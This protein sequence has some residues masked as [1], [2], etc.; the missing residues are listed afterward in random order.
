M[1]NS[2]YFTGKVIIITGA[3]SGIGLAS[4]RLFGSYGAKVV[5]AARR[6][7]LLQELGPSIAPS[8]NLLCVRCDVTRESDCRALIDAAIKRFSRIDILV[9]NAGVSMRAM[10]LDVELK[11]LKTLMDV[12]Y[13][14]TVYCTKAALPWLLESRGT[15]AGIISV[16][17]ISSLPARSGYSSSK[18]AVR[19]FLDAL[20]IE[21]LKDGLNV[22]VFAPGYTSSNVRNAA[23]IADGSPQ[24]NTPLNE[25]GLMSAEKVALKLAKAIKRRRNQVIL[26]SLGRL[27]AFLRGLCPSLLDRITYNYIAREGEVPK[28]DKNE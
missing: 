27:T 25:A 9:N 12:N 5:A 1:N 4:A 21:H 2:A 16:A 22:L 26:T 14:G 3:S 15:L 19:G 24:G 8:E 18:F 13:W 6:L 17:G 10:L 23:L 11:V 20:R 28:S 7:E